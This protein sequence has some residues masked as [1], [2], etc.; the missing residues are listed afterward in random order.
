[1][2]ELGKLARDDCEE[3]RDVLAH[4]TELWAQ[5]LFDLGKRQQA[6]EIVAKTVEQWPNNP[7]ALIARGKIRLALGQPKKALEDFEQAIGLAPNHG[8]VPWWLADRSDAHVALKEED[9]ALADLTEATERWPNHWDARMRR[10]HFY[11]DRSRWR[12]AIDDYA[13]AKGDRT[14][15]HRLGE[16]ASTWLVPCPPGD[17]GPS[18]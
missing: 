18:H 16:L 17:L 8:Y 14:L 7:H 1:M 9:K 15:P 2:P 4:A 5:M 12:E 11:R 10:G 6:E 13:E 3:H